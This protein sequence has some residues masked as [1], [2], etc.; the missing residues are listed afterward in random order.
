MQPERPVDK[1]YVST[2]VRNVEDVVSVKDCV[3]L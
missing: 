2:I 1:V 3:R